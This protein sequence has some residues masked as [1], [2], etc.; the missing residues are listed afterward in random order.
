MDDFDKTNLKNDNLNADS[1]SSEKQREEN[2]K[3]LATLLD[4]LD[5]IF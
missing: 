4:D 1:L 2:A 5:M 3:I